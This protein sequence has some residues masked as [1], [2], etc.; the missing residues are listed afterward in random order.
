MNQVKLAR[1]LLFKLQPLYLQPNREL[2]GNPPE[3]ARTLKQRLE[4]TREFFATSLYEQ[5][6]NSTYFIFRNSIDEK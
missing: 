3:V 4:G 1:N 5:N 2:R 6:F